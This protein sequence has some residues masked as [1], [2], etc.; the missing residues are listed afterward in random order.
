[1][2]ILFRLE[3]KKMGTASGIMTFDRGY[4]PGPDEPIMKS[5]LQQYER[6][7]IESLITTFGLDILIK[8]QHGGDVDTLLN[9][10]KIGEDPKMTYKLKQNRV[11]YENRGQY[12]KKM[13]NA[14]HS[15]SSCYRKTVKAAKKEF[16]EKGTK[17]ADTYVQGNEVIPRNKSIPREQQAQ[18]DHVVSAKEIH[19][20]RGRVLAGIDGKDLANSP[21]NLRYTNAALNKNMSCMS[22]KEYIAWCEQNPDK[23]NWCGKKGEPLPEEVKAKL[24]SEYNRAKGAY[25]AKLRRTY[26]TGVA[27][28]RDLA[29]AATNVSLRMG[30]RQALGFVFTEMWFA[31]KEN[32]GK[33]DEQ[34][35][36]LKAYL[37]SIAQGI[38]Q[39][40]ENAKQKYPE[41]FS[42]F[43]NGAVAGALSSITTTLC[44][45]FFTTAK[46]TVRVIRQ[47]YASL[48]EALKVLFINPDDYEFGDRMRAVAKILSV[49][50]STVVG[51]LVNEAVAQVP[52]AALGIAGD[53]LPTFC[54]VFVTGIMSCTL[55]L[56][57][58]RSEKINQLVQALNDI[59][60]IETELNYFRRQAEYF[61]A[62]AAQLM[63]IDL[64][65][66]KRETEAFCLIAEKINSVQSEAELNLVLKE[67]Y[68]SRNLPLPWEGFTD[69]DTFM[70][71]KSARLV[72]Q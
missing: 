20:D 66:F 1:M 50:A 49:G 27:F 64:E 14:Y 44:N 5:M 56:Y 4:N 21:D 69:F 46:N 63:Q 51:V 29:Y 17:I 22:A 57:L 41:L 7:L 8:D 55:L 47:C 24:L 58:D 28:R 70:N 72:F 37:E 54:G 52:I 25:D 38:K 48:V 71:S 11:N 2:Y 43:I 30:V 16:N 62:Y 45:I 33:L 60:T 18:L 68:I 53:A 10:R 39:G 23:V 61:E 59:H 31:V 12:D 19:E 15:G 13:S 65:R 32:I 42:K 26:Y 6:V 67:I 34:N 35:A 9:V 40:Y 36:D 3:M